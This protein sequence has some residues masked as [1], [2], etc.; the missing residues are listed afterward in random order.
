MIPVIQSVG[1]SDTISASGDLRNIVKTVA[2]IPALYIGSCDIIVNDKDADIV[3][4][5]AILLLVA[6]R[7]P[8]AEA[9]SLM[10]H[11]WYSVLLPARMFALLRNYIAPIVEDVCSKIRQQPEDWLH[12]KTW[13]PGSSSLRLVLQKRQWDGILQYL[14]IPDR[15]TADKAQQA[16]RATMLA[17]DRNF[18]KDYVD[19]VLFN[20]PPAWRVGMMKFLKDGILLPFGSSREDFDTPNP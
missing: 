8:P 18:W 13:V 4:R 5:N 11:V 2:K 14:R 17:P 3:A 7:F 16:R 12:S 1:R 10:L 20:L 9:A 15:L 19:H 6:L